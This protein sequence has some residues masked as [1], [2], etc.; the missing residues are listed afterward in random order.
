M[1]YPQERPKERTTLSSG[2]G[3][4]KVLEVDRALMLTELSDWQETNTP[5][6]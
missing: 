4:Y 1:V 5:P 2:E 3:G 6:R